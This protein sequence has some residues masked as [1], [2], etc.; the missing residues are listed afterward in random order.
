[1]NLKILKIFIIVFVFINCSSGRNLSEIKENVEKDTLRVYIE[2]DPYKL[3][4]NAKKSEYKKLVKKKVIE[5]GFNLLYGYIET[6]KKEE[7]N[8]KHVL[9]LMRKIIIK[10]E[11]KI[12]EE[13]DEKTRILAKYNIHEINKFLKIK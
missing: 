5:R 13:T 8:T 3:P 6:N 4:Y 2:I 9:I 11:I 7:I 12:I 1:M 10:P